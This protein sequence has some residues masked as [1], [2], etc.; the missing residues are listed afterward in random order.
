M[1]IVVGKNI[2]QLS[3]NSGQFNFH[4]VVILDQF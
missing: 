4:D 3:Q 1:L 2:K